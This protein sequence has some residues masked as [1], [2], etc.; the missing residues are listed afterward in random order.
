RAAGAAD[1][2]Y[3]GASRR[4]VFH[5]ADAS[6]SGLAWG[7]PMKLDVTAVSWSVAGAQIVREVTLTGP[8]GGFV[9]LIGPNGSGKSS[10]LRCIYRVLPPDTGAIHLGA[11]DVWQLSAR[12]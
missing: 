5:L 4:A 10:L 8:P 9:G 12:Q 2:H 1:R 11:D 6:R 7:W 3:H